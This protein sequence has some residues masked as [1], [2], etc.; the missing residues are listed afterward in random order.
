MAYTYNDGVDETKPDGA[1]TPANTIDS[2]FVGVKQAINERMDYL[3]GGDFSSSTEQTIEKLAG[4]VTFSGAGK[5]A[6]QTLTA[7]G[8]ITGATTLDFDV[9]GNYISATLTGAVTFTFSNMRAGTTYVLLLTQ[10]GTGGY[11][12]TWP[13]SVRWPGGTAPSINT[14]ASRCTLITITP[15]SGSIAL[16]SLAGTNYN[17]S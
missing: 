1:T 4:A 2:V 10:N 15:I 6:T 3:F 17:V 5:Q 9:R 7:V 14:T 8:N 16:G 12:I 11:A 13:S